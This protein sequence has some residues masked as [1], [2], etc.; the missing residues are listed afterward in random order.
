M[1][2]CV[3]AYQIISNVFSLDGGML[4]KVVDKNA[5]FLDL[6][7][8]P[9]YKQNNF[10]PDVQPSDDP[11]YYAELSAEEVYEVMKDVIIERQE[12]KKARERATKDIWLEPDSVA[13]NMAKEMYEKGENETMEYNLTIWT[14]GFNIAHVFDIQQILRP[15]GVKII[16]RSY[17]SLCHYIGSCA[18]DMF[19]L[20]DRS[21]LL[22]V[23]YT[24]QSIAAEYV[25]NLTEIKSAD[26]IMCSYPVSLCHL[27]KYQTKPVLF[28]AA[29]RYEIGRSSSWRMWNYYV[30]DLGSRDNSILAARDNYDSVYI[31]YFTGS[32]PIVVPPHCGYIKEFYNPITDH[33]Y[34]YSGPKAAF[35]EDF[36][37][38]M[39][40]A[41]LKNDT[42]I[43]LVYKTEITS[44]LHN[45]K[46]IIYI[47]HKVNSIQFTELYRMNVPLFVPSLQLLIEWEMSERVLVDR[48]FLNSTKSLKEGGSIMGAK[49]EGIP[50]PNTYSRDALTY[51]LNLLEY[52]NMPGVQY[53]DSVGHLLDLLIKDRSLWKFSDQMKQQNNAVKEIIESSWK[54]IV[55]KFRQAKTKH[56]VFLDNLDNDDEDNIFKILNKM[57]K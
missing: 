39:H 11:D 55:E 42:K 5:V 38:E 28:L 41:A 12:I 46:A 10:V 52:Y 19:P 49:K 51:W 47:P 21:K 25:K 30:S 37:T 57:I 4:E 16:N 44:H 45:N 17:S 7:F 34:I 32:S 23:P 36:V 22:D 3:V 24:Y 20:F 15:L 13:A 40:E 8:E 6:K 27:I 35:M 50:D 29:N 43:S 56:V 14:M 26:V 18:E 9:K 31:K 48:V 33:V 54:S 53:F 1:V 2:L